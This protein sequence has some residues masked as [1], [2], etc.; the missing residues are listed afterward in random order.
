MSGDTG[1][2]EM[3]KLRKLRGEQGQA[4]VE[5]A[6]VAPFL[7]LILFAIIQFGITFNHYLNLTDAVRAAARQAVVTHDPNAAKT[8]AVNAA[9]G[10]SGFTTDN[11]NVTVDGVTPVGPIAVGKDVTVSATYPYSINLLGLVVKTGN[12]TS[13]TTERVD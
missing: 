6:L 1:D 8:T 12:L 3:R 4:T 10:L 11:V 2:G 13:S 7:L 9:G 5:F